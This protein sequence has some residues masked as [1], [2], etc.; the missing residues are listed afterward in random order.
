M[1]YF[2]KLLVDSFKDSKECFYFSK[3]LVFLIVLKT[4]KSSFVT[5]ELKTGPRFVDGSV[6]PG[7][8]GF[9]A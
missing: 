3:L 8:S 1:F 7:C 5:R 2:S 6:R 9:R 4:T